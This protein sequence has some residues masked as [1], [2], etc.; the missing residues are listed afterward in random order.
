MHELGVVFAIMDTVEGFAKQN[1]ITKVSA[2]TVEKGEVSSVIDEYLTDCWNWSVKKNE[3]FLDTKLFIE[4]IP[5]ITL[6][7]QCKQ[8]YSTVKYA[9]VC[10]HCG[11]EDTVLVQGNELQIKDI[12]V[13]DEDMPEGMETVD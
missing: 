13:Y 1:G 6:C 2:V 5:A 3:L 12:G 10:P 8:T 9:K 11:S 4:T 7:N